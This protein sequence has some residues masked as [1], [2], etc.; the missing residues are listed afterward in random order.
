MEWQLPLVFPGTKAGGENE[1]VDQWDSE[2]IYTVFALTVSSAIQTGVLFSTQVMRHSMRV[3][4]LIPVQHEFLSL[5]HHL[6]VFHYVAATVGLD[7]PL[8][9]YKYVLDQYRG[10]NNMHSLL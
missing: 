6:P 7:P 4:I 10:S 1:A 2:R 3:S 8:L 5:V 9:Q